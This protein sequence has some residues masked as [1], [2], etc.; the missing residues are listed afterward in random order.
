MKKQLPTPLVIAIIVLAVGGIFALLMQ[1]TSTPEGEGDISK[2]A[3]EVKSKAPPDFTPEQ[4][5]ANTV[6]RGKK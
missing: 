2:I 4:A 5:S 3:A 1:S 6:M